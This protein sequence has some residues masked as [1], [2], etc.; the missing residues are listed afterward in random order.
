MMTTPRTGTAALIVNRAGQYLLHLRDDRPIAEP[1]TFAFL[2][3]APEGAESLREAIVRELKEEAGLSIADLRPFTVVDSPA[4]RIQ[5]FLGHWD[6]DAAALPLRE[7]I[8]LHWF[9]HAKLPDLRLA[10]GAREAIE[11]HRALSQ[12]VAGTGPRTVQGEQ[13]PGTVDGSPLRHP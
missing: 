1:F 11:L 13:Q 4:R 10:H 2:G 9:D 12:H 6:G 5:V 8:L 3:G 7:G